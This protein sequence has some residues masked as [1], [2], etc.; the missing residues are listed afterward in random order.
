MRAL[1]LLLPHLWPAL[2]ASSKT[3]TVGGA[4]EASGIVTTLVCD[5]GD[6]I[7]IVSSSYGPTECAI[8]PQPG[9]CPQGNVAGGCQKAKTS[10]T[11]N[12][13]AQVTAKC[14]GKSSCHVAA[15]AIPD[16]PPAGA[17]SCVNLAADPCDGCFKSFVTVYDCNK[18]DPIEWGIVGVLAIGG[19]GY[20]LGGLFLAAKQAGKPLS[21]GSLAAVEHPHV[22]Y[23]RPLRGLV[24]DGLAFSI[25]QLEKKG[26]SVPA[27]IKSKL[28]GGGGGGGY[29]SV[30]GV[31]TAGEAEPEPEPE[32]EPDDG[33]ASEGSDAGSSSD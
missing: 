17:A 27:V 7:V 1:L 8:P 32:P 24:L 3:A 10:T 30:A 25:A 6:Q 29:E 11:N 22:A 23:F 16:L 20:V 21:L 28:G 13:L 33:T 31:A 5:A 15:C 4:T 2:V 12:L 18:P 26:V 14:A 9:G 19:V